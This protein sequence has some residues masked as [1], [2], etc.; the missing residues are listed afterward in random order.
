[1][2]KAQENS[3]SFSHFITFALYIMFNGYRITL[4]FTN[5]HF[6]GNVF[7]VYPQLMGNKDMYN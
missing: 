7:T 4:K 5:D 2:A 1:M 6:C 3:A